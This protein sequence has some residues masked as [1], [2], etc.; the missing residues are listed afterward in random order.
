MLKIHTDHARFKKI[1]RGSIKKNLKQHI[2]KGEMIGRKGGKYVSIPIPQIEI[3]RFRFGQQGGGG[4]GQGE[5]EEGRAVQPEAGDEAGRHVLEVE[6][7]LEELAAIMAEELE[8]PNIKPRGR[9]EIE[10]L[11]D[12]YTSL[13]RTGPESLRQFKRTYTAALKRQIASGSYDKNNP[14]VIPIREDRRYRS[15][16]TVEQPE[17]SA[18]IIYMMDVSGSMGD[19][20]K[21]IV[22]LESFWIDTWLQSQYKNIETRY[23]IHDAAAHE[24]D[25][26]TFYHTRESGGT[27]ISTAYDLCVSILEKD[28]PVTE[29]NIYPFH[30][31][32]GDNWGGGDTELALSILKEK[33]LP[34]SNQ[35]SYGQVKSLYGTGQFIKD[36]RENGQ[37][38]DRIV[39]SEINSKDDI[40]R[41]IQDFLKS[42]R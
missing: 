6:V 26:E 35:F 33:L 4:V 22:R 42:G 18:V 2:T 8:L 29:W 31:S 1:V 20:Q 27:K 16:K 40:Y 36:L 37:E 39:L 21:E 25:R 32:D 5:G 19:E 24:V 30:F 12:R 15:W 3:P 38:E 7:S 34:V 13:R 41:S 10:E 17:S 14:V 11:R 23:I 9:M 28:F